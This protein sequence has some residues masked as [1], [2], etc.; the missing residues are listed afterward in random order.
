MT[1]LPEKWSFGVEPLPQTVR[2]ASL[3]RRVLG[4][5]LALEHD[6]P[7]V[8]RLIE[9]LEAA[10]GELEC[11]LPSDPRP[12]LGPHTVPS[13]RVYLDHSRDVGAYNPCFPEYAIN[14]DGERA[15]GRVTFPLPYE[16]PPG[17]VHGGVL[18]TF[19]DCVIQHHNCDFG[20]AG[21]TTSLHLDYLRPTPV[22]TQL[23][24]DIERSGGERRISS[25][26]TLSLEGT[27]LCR[28]TME[29]VSGD[30]A[31]LPE[32]SPRRIRP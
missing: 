11:D 1:S 3:V 30:R 23:D 6:H 31:R 2:V 21:K 10:E 32:V 26:A 14:T 25:T 13:Q 4:E 20:V 18:A 8:A 5:V 27:L 24:F 9:E 22:L 7:A 19:F 28:A 12:R 29:A 16:G 15:S 17:V